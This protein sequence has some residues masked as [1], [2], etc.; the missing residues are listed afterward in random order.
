MVPSPAVPPVPREG[1]SIAALRAFAEQHKGAVCEPTEAER[2][3]A[4][5]E[6]KPAPT[7]LPFAT[8]STAQVVSRVIKPATK[9]KHCSYAELLRGKADASGRPHVGLAT[10][11]VS[12]AWDNA[13]ADLQDALMERFGA[14]EDVFLWNG[15]G[16]GAWP[17]AVAHA[18][19][20]SA[21]GSRAVHAA[22]RSLPPHVRSRLLLRRRYLCGQPACGCHAPAGLVGHCVCICSRRD[23]PYC[24]GAAAVGQAA[25]ADALLVPGAV[26]LRAWRAS[27]LSV[28]CAQW[29][30]LATLNAP[31]CRF[32]VL[33]T[34][35]QRDAFEIT[36]RSDFELILTALCAI[37]TREAKAGKDADKQMIDAAVLKTAGGYVHVNGRIQE[38]LRDWVAQR[39]LDA[40]ARLQAGQGSCDG[41]DTTCLRSTCCRASAACCLTWAV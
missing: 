14:D 40:L 17:C 16:G 12:H 41:S 24:L 34:S 22:V 10:V 36:L 15:V 29:E 5:R 31:H 11:F 26:R 13:F 7:A 30:I 3:F 25:A 37:D 33:L 28:A 6:R 18:I 35:A 19:R 23:R 9:H 27:A 20:A 39:G 21:G 32:D 4:Q 2:A 38:R 8:L 1:L